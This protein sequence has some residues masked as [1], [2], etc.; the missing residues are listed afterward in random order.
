MDIYEL[1]PR[2][3]SPD[4]KSYIFYGAITS[5]FLIS[6]IASLNSVA[7]ASALPAI[8][9]GLDAASDSAFWTGTAF[10]LCQTVTT[11]IFGVF[12]EFLGRKMILLGC[13]LAFMIATALCSTAQNIS[14]LI[15]ARV[16]RLKYLA[17]PIN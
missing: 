13:L 9:I 8:T 2:S 17:R 12:S 11:P 3:K 14:W 10:L 1:L 6:L 5:L 15:G 4:G 7:L 16:V